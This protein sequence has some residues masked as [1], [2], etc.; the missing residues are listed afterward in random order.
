MKDFRLNAQHDIEIVNGDFSFVDDKEL[1]RQR[2]EMLLGTNQGENV[3]DEDEGIDF[4][5]LLSKTSD[6]ETIRS[7]IQS[8]LEQLD[9]GFDIEDFSCVR[10]GRT[11]V[12]NFKATDSNGESVESEYVYE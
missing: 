5:V 12:V 2:V 3:L 1:L 7:E 11:L 6:E 4:K 9:E 8:A 10:E